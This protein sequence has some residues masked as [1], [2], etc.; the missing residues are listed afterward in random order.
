MV[1]SLHTASKMVS[2][3]TGKKFDKI[4]LPL[5]EY[6]QVKQYMSD[7]FFFIFPEEGFSVDTI[8]ENIPLKTKCTY[9]KQ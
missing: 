3:I 2:K 7:N 4:S 5:N 9:V 1:G 6:R 8:L